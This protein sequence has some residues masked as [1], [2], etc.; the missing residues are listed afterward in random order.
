MS[1]GRVATE[2]VLTIPFWIALLWLMFVMAAWLN[3]RIQLP[4]FLV[5][6]LLFFTSLVVAHRIACTVVRRFGPP[7]LRPV[8]G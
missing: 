7:W 2:V 3:A 6:D 8:E 1:V 5:I 4:V